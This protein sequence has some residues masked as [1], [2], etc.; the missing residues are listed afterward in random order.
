MSTAPAA[1]RPISL[2]IYMAAM[3]ILSTAMLGIGERNI[4]LPVLTLVTA[5]ASVI[6]TDKL[7]WFHL[8]RVLAHIAMLL[9]AFASLRSFFNL[10]SYQQLISIA[11]LLVY[12]Q[13]VLLLQEKNRRI[14]GQLAVFSLLQVV[15]ASLLNNHLGFGLLLFLYLIVA[16]FALVHF[17]VYR[18]WQRAGTT[19]PTPRTTWHFW[20]RTGL[21]A[22][23][24]S[25]P[26]V[27][28]GQIEL[29]GKHTLQ[30][31]TLI[32][33]II[34]MIVG[35]VAFAALFFYVAPHGNGMNWMR[36]SR[37]F[38]KVGFSPEI[39][40]AKM[41]RVLQSNERVMR[42]SF[43]DA[44]TKKPYTVIGDPYFHGGLLLHY[45]S[46]DGHGRWRQS[47]DTRRPQRLGEPPSNAKDIVLQDVLMEPTGADLLFSV[48]PVYSAGD[49]SSDIR[50]RHRTRQVIRTYA[51]TEQ[52]ARE[53][54]YRVTTTAF[55]FG[56]QDHISLVLNESRVYE[57]IRLLDGRVDGDQVLPKLIALAK[58]IV[59]KKAPEG[60]TYDRAKA[61]EQHFHEKD[62]YHYSLDFDEIN[63]H[64]Q[65]QVDPIEDFVSNHRT[66]H[67]EYFAS[68]L[69]L[70]LR[71]VGIPS[72][73]IVGYHGGKYNYVGHYYVVRQKHAHAWVEAYI[74]SADIPEEL[75][76]SDRKFPRGV[77]LRLE[78]T[79]A[80]DDGQ[81]KASAL[82]RVTNSFDYAQWLWN[83]YVLHLADTQRRNTPF[84]QRTARRDEAPPQAMLPSRVWRM[85]ARQFSLTNLREIVQR[86]FSWRGGL[87]AVFICLLVYGV[88]RALRK[89]VP[90]VRRVRSKYRHRSIG[91]K[92]SVAFYRQLE[93][94][95]GAAGMHRKPCETPRELADK[96]AE[97]LRPIVGQS[98]LAT[99]PI[100]IVESYYR[101]RFGSWK[102]DGAE[103]AKIEQDLQQLRQAIGDH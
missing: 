45:V 24:R 26:D 88:Y 84:F 17:F 98:G 11:N 20:S 64:R 62:L 42:V 61:L 43:R 47:I 8:H 102:P 39:S 53:Y 50:V 79:P 41:G 85:V 25:Q 93:R 63:R 92:S 15:V 30:P 73:I 51:L 28:V 59:E 10:G 80:P 19:T 69:V 6:L 37:A 16:M 5:T 31:R 22:E 1:S 48:L 86:P 55:R 90:F 97:Q 2:S 99:V 38:S 78:P 3:A 54:R 60:N 33:P 58:E 57:A 49:A 44:K 34:S 52:L 82:D 75:L 18:E 32:A 29:V 89:L 87:A 77:W 70:M 74:E 56:T 103:L 68:A 91:H 12:V 21:A 7:Q 9:A 46:E 81:W 4:V 100:H 94:I 36:N 66:G 67:C 72:R 27:M 35:S 13:M 23:K 40:F 76:A 96:A 14:Y 95:L 71:S 83:D 65:S 101:T